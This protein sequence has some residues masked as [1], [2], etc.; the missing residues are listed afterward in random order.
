MFFGHYYPQPPIYYLPCPHCHRLPYPLPT[1]TQ[2][3]VLQ[4]PEPQ[5]NIPVSIENTE[6]NPVPSENSPKLKIESPKEQEKS[7]KKVVEAQK[8]IR[9]R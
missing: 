7:H 9:R 4:E 1:D 8:Q 2:E 3:P 5:Q 6:N